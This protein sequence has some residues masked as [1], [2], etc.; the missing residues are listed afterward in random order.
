MAARKVG[1]ICES[2]RSRW[3]VCS[4]AVAHRP[5]S[6]GVGEISVFVAVSSVH[7]G[8]S[9]DACSYL[10]DEI[11]GSVPI[12]KKEVY[13]DGGCGKRLGTHEYGRWTKNVWGMGKKN[14]A[15]A[16][17]KDDHAHLFRKKVVPTRREKRRS[18][19]LLISTKKAK[20]MKS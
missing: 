6:V 15:Y 18:A 5:R 14:G 20:E 17:S 19:T 11:K 12:W 1:S 2:A 7:I 16:Y 13:G 10:I 3:D 8:E 9:L 4:V